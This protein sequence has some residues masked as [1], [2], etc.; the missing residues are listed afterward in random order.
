MFLFDFFL[1]ALTLN[2]LDGHDFE[3]YWEAFGTT[4]YRQLVKSVNQPYSPVSLNVVTNDLIAA[5]KT[6]FLKLD[7]E[8]SVPISGKT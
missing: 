1:G 2:K 5:F 8:L 7:F 4:I 6:K 3:K